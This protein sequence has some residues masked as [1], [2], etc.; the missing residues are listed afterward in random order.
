[1]PLLILQLSNVFC[2]FITPDNFEE[3]VMGK[4]EYIFKN[5]EDYLALNYIKFD[6]E[7]L[8]TFFKENFKPLCAYCQTKFNLDIDLAKEVVQTGFIKLWET[9]NHIS[10]GLSAKAYLYKIISNNCLDIIRHEKIKS[11][12]EIHVKKNT[13]TRL[14]D[15]N[16][17]PAEVEQLAKAIDKSIAGLPEQMRN[18]FELSRYQGLKYRQ[19]AEL[20]NISVKTVE[21]QMSRA[22]LKLRQKLT[23]YLFLILFLVMLY[24]NIL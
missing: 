23:D 7:K 10:P 14:F 4:T 21:T 12:Y 22:L 24:K 6:E 17:S 1:M 9:R 20:L 16:S 3:T 13:V 8:E 18:I 15:E 2:F 19:I 11:K 5:D